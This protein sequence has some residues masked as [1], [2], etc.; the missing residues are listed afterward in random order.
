MRSKSEL[1]IIAVAAFS[2]TMLLM[3]FAGDSI[4]LLLRTIIYA[5]CI[6]GVIG[7]LVLKNLLS[8]ARSSALRRLFGIGFFFYAA[9][10]IA[11]I[12][13]DKSFVVGD[14]LLLGMEPATA[15]LV[16]GVTFFPFTFTLLWLIGFDQAIVTPEKEEHLKKLTE[17]RKGRATDG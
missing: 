16:F 14:T 13:F 8:N 7:V 1:P 5:V 17:E 3:A 12:L 10:L 15:M 2:G 4:P 9:I 11:I 6:M